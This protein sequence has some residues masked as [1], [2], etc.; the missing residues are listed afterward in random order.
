VFIVVAL[1]LFVMAG[2]AAFAGAVAMV[3]DPE[4]RKF[5]FQ[6]TGATVLV[7]LVA[8]TVLYIAVK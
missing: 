3:F 5:G 7:G 6:A 8:L 2:L 1:G 4:T